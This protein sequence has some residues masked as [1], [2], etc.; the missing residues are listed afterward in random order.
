MTLVDSAKLNFLPHIQLKTSN[1]GFLLR[2]ENF[3]FGCRHCFKR[4]SNFLPTNVPAL[5][6][7]VVLPSQLATDCVQWTSAC[8]WPREMPKRNRYA[9]QKEYFSLAN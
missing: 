5:P 8:G 7:P 9:S 1:L 2:P 3:I 4:P 6:R